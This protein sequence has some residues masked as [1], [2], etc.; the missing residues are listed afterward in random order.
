MT[1]PAA[2]KAFDIHAEPEKLRETYGRHSLGQSCLMAR[3]LVEAGV[4]CVTVAYGFWDTH[5]GNFRHL[6]GNL[7][8][9]D[10]GISAL[11]DDLHQRGLSDDVTV[12]VWGEFGRTQRINRDAG[13]DHWAPVNC[14]L[15][16]GGGIPTG[17][18][19]GGTDHRGDSIKERKVTPSDLAATV[20]GHLR[21]PLE[22]HWVNPQGRPI[23]IVTEGGRP[24]P[25]LC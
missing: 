11:V 19:I 24:I 21:I 16:A 3:R 6:R 1:S 25:E 2:K 4:R 20:F 7:P 18:V 8:M 13:R 22:A 10:R 5:G 9:F 23:P 15:L 17:Q 12:L 14:G